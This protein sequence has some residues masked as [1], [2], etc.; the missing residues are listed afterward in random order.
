MLFLLDTGDEKTV[1]E[2]QENQTYV[3]DETGPVFV[4]SKHHLLFSFKG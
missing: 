1:L 4:W 3:G 2:N